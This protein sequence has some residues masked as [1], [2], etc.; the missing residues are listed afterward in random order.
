MSGHVEGMRV[1]PV[2]LALARSALRVC[3][4]V[5]RAIWRFPG[6]GRLAFVP[7][8]TEPGGE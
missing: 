1:S 7:P 4:F 3:Y 6:P 5:I 8:I 2:R